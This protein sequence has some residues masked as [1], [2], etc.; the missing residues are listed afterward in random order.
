ML[1]YEERQTYVVSTLGAHHLTQFLIPRWYEISQV[2]DK[3]A[4][5][6][7]LPP[8][9]PAPHQRPYTLLISMEDLLTASTWDVCLCRF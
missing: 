8:P 5:K 4:W 9:L 1:V 2:F 6:E 7:L 3:P